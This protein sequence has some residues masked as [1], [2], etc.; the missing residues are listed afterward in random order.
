M[1]RCHIT[2]ARLGPDDILP[3]AVDMLSC[4][5]LD[6]TSLVLVKTLR[7]VDPHT[8]RPPDQAGVFLRPVLSITSYL[9]QIPDL[10]RV[11]ISALDSCTTGDLFFA[12]TQ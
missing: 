12:Y 7:L 8:T 6:W 11:S 9:F 2:K 3:D 10:N 1:T 4:F 5:L